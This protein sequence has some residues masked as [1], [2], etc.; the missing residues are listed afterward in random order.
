MVAKFLAFEIQN[1]SSPVTLSLSSFKKKKKNPI[2]FSTA[3]SELHPSLPAFVNSSPSFAFFHIYHHPP[4]SFT[5]SVLL[6]F[7]P[8]ISPF[9]FHACVPPL[10]TPISLISL[11]G[12]CHCENMICSH[13]T[14]D[15]TLPHSHHAPGLPYGACTCGLAYRTPTAPTGHGPASKITWRVKHQ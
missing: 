6:C 2:L 1:T 15:Y 7:F 14:A 5:T 9:L 8:V 11:W 10:L 4:S 12:S 3:L 13:Q